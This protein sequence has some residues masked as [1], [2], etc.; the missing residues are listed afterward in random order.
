[1]LVSVI[2]IN[3]NNCDGLRHTIKSVARQECNNFEYIVID[4]GSTD[5][6][7][8]VIKEYAPKIDFWV[9]EPDGGIYNAMN[10]AIDQFKH[11]NV[12]FVFKGN[13]VGIDPDNPS[14]TYDLRQGYIEN[15]NTSYPLFHYV[16]SD[17]IT[18]ID[19]SDS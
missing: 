3:Y 10:K 7:V 4:G 14:D 9:S 5:S 13:N 18:I 16:L 19:K 2:T 8:E 11:G 17:A 15:E 12:D 1:M 6:S